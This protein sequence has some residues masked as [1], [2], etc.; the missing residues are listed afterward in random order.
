MDQK[1]G[2]VFQPLRAVD[3]HQTDAVFVSPFL[4]LRAKR[5]PVILHMGEPAFHIFV[6]LRGLLD[7][8][9]SPEKLLFIQSLKLGVPFQELIISHAFADVLN[10][11]KRRFPVQHLHVPL[12]LIDP[13]HHPIF[14][15]VKVP[16]RLIGNIRL[17]HGVSSNVTVGTVCN[18]QEIFPLPVSHCQMKITADINGSHMVIDITDLLPHEKRDLIFRQCLG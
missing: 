15:T 16:E 13:V 7:L 17:L 4:F 11:R 6:M 1:Y 9:Q 3:R 2:I 5:F 14:V 18:L 8:I 10:G 12:P